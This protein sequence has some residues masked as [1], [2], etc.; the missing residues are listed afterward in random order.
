[1]IYAANGKNLITSMFGNFSDNQFEL[2]ACFCSLVRSRFT[3]PLHRWDSFLMKCIN[4]YLD[5]HTLCTSSGV[6]VVEFGFKLTGWITHLYWKLKITNYSTR[7]GVPTISP[8]PNV[9][10]NSV[11]L[12]RKHW[13]YRITTCFWMPWDLIATCSPDLEVGA[14]GFQW[15]FLGEVWAL[16]RCGMLDFCWMRL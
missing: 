5:I 8:R 16:W 12:R 7:T 9:C 13:S 2:K 11:F 6:F 1:M 10:R 4:M 14:W 15:K 3:S